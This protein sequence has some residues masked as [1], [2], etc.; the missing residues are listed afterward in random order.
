MIL[1]LHLLVFKLNKCKI[2]RNS[3]HHPKDKKY[4]K[5]QRL[6]DR[7]ALIIIA[8]YNLSITLKLVGVIILKVT[9]HDEEWVRIVLYVAITVI[10]TMLYLFVFE[11]RV[12]FLKIKSE[13]AE[14][15]QIRVGRMQ[16]FK[17]ATIS[18]LLVTMTILVTL[19]AIQYIIDDPKLF[20]DNNFTTIL[21]LNYSARV[22]KFILDVM[23]FG[24]FAHL[25]KYYILK[26]KEKLESQ[27]QTFSK[28]NKLVIVWIGI[29]YLMNLY[30]SVIS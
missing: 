25:L 19:L 11:M 9:H 21:V 17:V 4:Y 29:L 24:I 15:Q 14:E 12:V 1:E 6:I 3:Q 7:S 8:F 26:K 23:M 18:S 2:S 27:G 30:H 5:D 10:W 13:T 28:H 16:R 20:V 22:S